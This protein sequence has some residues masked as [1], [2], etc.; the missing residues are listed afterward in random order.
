MPIRCIVH[1]AQVHSEFRLPELESIAELYDFRFSRPAPGSLQDSSSED[2]D[3]MRPFWVMDFEREEHARYLA[4]RC[5]L[6][7]SVYELYGRGSSYESVYAQTRENK[8]LWVPYAENTSFRFT[9]MGY[10]YSIPLRRVKEI[11]ESFRFMDFRGPIDLKN[12]ELTLSVFEEYAD[13]GT[14]TVRNRHGGDGEFS[15]IYFGRLVAE[16]KA[17]ALVGKFDVKKRA[18]FGNTSMEAEISLLMANQTLASPGKFI[19]DPFIGTGSMAYTVAHFGALVFGSDI[20]GRQMRGKYDEPGILRAAAQ[21]GVANRVLDLCTFDIT[22]N[23]LRCGGLFDA[24]ITDPPYGVRAGAKR[25]GRK[26]T[27]KKADRE[28]KPEYDEAQRK[29]LIEYVPPKHAYELSELVSDL[30]Q[31]ARYLLR[32]NGRLV[33]FL[34]TVTDEYAEVDVYS[35]LCEGMEVV[36]NSV[37]SFGSWGRRLITIKKTTGTY[38]PSPFETSKEGKDRVSVSA[39]D[40]TGNGGHVPAHKDFREKYFK[41]FRRDTDE[42]EP[43]MPQVGQL[44]E[45]NGGRSG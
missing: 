6:V 12:P 15:Q 4:E 40:R 5:I 3:P 22:R 30:V 27:D 14:A 2:W 43:G 39:P 26:P 33:F 42:N 38:Y 29:G 44:T 18:Y 11:V 37:Q 45:Q 34:P 9:V 21:Y 8:H 1:F 10:N 7:K 16:G 36:A 32:P 20:D 25:L 23:P 17:R 31:F 19:Y 13:R 35:M 24:I 28:R 41:G